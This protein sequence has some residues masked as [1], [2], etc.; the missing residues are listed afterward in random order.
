MSIL[1]TVDDILF[2][3]QTVI[4]VD[5][6][7]PCDYFH[8]VACTQRKAHNAVENQPAKRSITVVDPAEYYEEVGRLVSKA[9]RGRLT[10]DE[11]ARRVALTRT[12]ITNIEKG[13]QRVML[14]TLAQIADALGTSISKLLPDLHEEAGKKLNQALKDHPK[15]TRDWVTSAL[16]MIK[17]GTPQ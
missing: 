7:A 5:V 10:Q 16:P 17:K 12:S 11:L 6:G 14:H 13:R 3:L 1:E 2:V 8:N 9:R 4:V 15:S